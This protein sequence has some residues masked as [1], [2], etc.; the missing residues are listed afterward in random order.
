[1]SNN[2]D[3]LNEFLSEKEDRYINAPF[4]KCD[5]YDHIWIIEYTD[6][7]QREID[8][9]I[10]ISDV[11]LLTSKKNEKLLNSLKYWIIENIYNGN[12]HIA[13][14]S[15]MSRRVSSVL[16]IFDCLILCD[17]KNQ[18]L[19]SGFESISNSKFKYVLDKLSEDSDKFE[20][21][22]NNSE[23][24]YNYYIEKILKSKNINPKGSLS[25]LSNENIKLLL[26]NLKENKVKVAHLY[27]DTLNKPRVW[28]E[29]LV[30]ASST[31]SIRE[32]K[33]YFREKKVSILSEGSLL[34]YK[35]A[36]MSLK[37]I[38]SKKEKDNN[39][40]YPELYSF[41]SINQYKPETKAINRFET[42]PS[43]VIF[44]I[45]KKAVEFH[46]EYGAEI[47][48]TYSI[49]I[50][51]LKKKNVNT[52]NFKMNIEV[53]DIFKNSLSTKMIEMGVKELKSDYTVDSKFELLR[54]N[55]CLLDLLKVYYGVVQ[56]V[57]GALM[58]R[59]QSELTS[60]IAGECIDEV[61]GVML[62]K[63]S[64]STKGLFGTKDTLALPIDSL[65]IDMI[66]N[67]E[68]IHK[69]IGGE[70]K[71]FATPSFLNP[72][73]IKSTSEGGYY[74]ENLDL[75][76]D[77]IEAPL[78]EGKRLYIRQHQLRRFFAMSF[79]WSS[80]FGSMDTLRWFMGHTDIQHLYHYITESTSGEVLRGVK[81]QY[82][83]EG[84][85]KYE[86]LANLIKD[87][88]K[89]KE[90]DLIESEDLIEYIE[91]LIE[92]EDITVEPD[93]FHDDN[94]NKFEIVVKINKQ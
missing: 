2:L 35:R 42:Y 56:F 31:R 76:F 82:V 60:L 38:T 9:N 85:S 49:F 69:A 70:N 48:N 26:N 89:T 22:Y 64:K 79:F 41:D 55:S 18:I 88:Y 8:F 14:K 68:K 63:R 7:T 90:F 54:C 1:M 52:S 47:T 62:F 45:F 25:D 23:R 19:K 71:L 77:Y 51:D 10:I 91:D 33:G 75:F 80:G 36:I 6:N 40:I 34:H 32:F 92:N 78:I 12:A 37:S 39:F 17:S 5:F 27:P 65:A 30:S 83:A 3:F 4:L 57:V 84:I 93:F 29:L 50:K 53:N 11:E 72:T 66:K 59:R 86:D 87:K 20:N 16:T 15:T 81:A 44:D 28:N 58:A 13:S 67:L 73:V 43:K 24:F 94:E 46:L 21:I 61:N 74:S